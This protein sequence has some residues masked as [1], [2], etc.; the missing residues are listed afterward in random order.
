MAL[1]MALVSREFP[2]DHGGG[3]GSYAARIAR[4]LAGIGVRVHVITRHLT[5]TEREPDWP[6]G[7]TVHR[8]EMGDRSGPS[9]LRASMVVAAKILD[10]VRTHGLDAIEFAEYEAMGSAWLALRRLDA[11]ASQIPVA[12]HLHSPTELNA[13][14]NGYSAADLDP[15]LSELIE[16]ERR[17]IS[18]A[19]GVCAPGS[20]MADW[21]HHRYAL[22]VAPK[23]IPY[24][25][26]VSVTPR[27]EDDAKV[28]L[29]VGR[30]ERR[31]G[32]DTLIRAWNRVAAVRSGW[33]LHLVG[34]DTNTAPGGGS[35]RAW[36]EAMLEPSAQ[37]CT[38]FDAAMA[39]LQLRA[40]RATCS[41]AVIPSRWENF[42][43]TCIEAMADGLPV[44]ASDHGGMAEMLGLPAMS[45]VADGPCGSVFP[46]GDHDSLADSLQRWMSMQPTA[47]ISAGVAAQC[48]IRRICDPQAVARQ[49]IEWLVSLKANA[50]PAD[51]PL[52]RLL[53][54]GP[55]S[56]TRCMSSTLQLSIRHFDMATGA[57][58]RS[59][60]PSHWTEIMRSTLAGVAQRNGSPA[61]LYGAGHFTRSIGEALR[62]APAKIVCIIDDDPS[63]QG[64]S[65][66]G[67]PIVSQKEA[68]A[69]GVR[70]VVLSANQ[71][72]DKLWRAAQPMRDAGVEVVRLFSRHRPRVMIIESGEN[73]NHF[74]GVA[75]QLKARGIEVVGDTPH[76][77]Y[78][79]PDHELDLVCVADVLA[80]RNIAILRAARAKGIRTLLMMDGAVEYRNTFINPLAGP[81]FLRPAPIDMI[82]C[83]TTD[84]E[85]HL[86]ML[87]N[88]A[89]ATGLPRLDA[90][91]VVPHDPSGPVLISTANTPWFNEEERLRLHRV[92]SDMRTVTANRALQVRWRLTGGL[93]RALGIANH[94]GSLSDAMSGCRGVISTPST[95]LLEA[96]MAGLPIGVLDP[97]GQPVLDGMDGV[98][99]DARA[100][101]LID[102]IGNCSSWLEQSYPPWMSGKS[103]ASMVAEHIA[104]IVS[105]KGST[106]ASAP[107][108]ETVRLPDRLKRTG[109]PRAVSIIV[110][111]GSSTSGV[112]TF[113]LRMSEE[114]TAHTSGW[115]WHTLLVQTKPR[116]AADHG[117]RDLHPD[118]CAHVH[119]CVLD[120]TSDHHETLRA[121]REAVERLNP[122]VLVP[123]FSDMAW[124]V[125]AQ[126]R[127]RGVRVL[128]IMHSDDEA[129]RSTLRERP[130]WDAGVAVSA[131]CAAQMRRIASENFTCVPAVEQIT[132]GVPVEGAFPERHRS[133]PLRLLYIGRLVEHQK[134]VSRLVEVAVHLRELGCDYQLDVIGDG[135]CEKSL[136]HD[137]RQ[138]KL[139]DALRIRGGLNP[140]AV[141]RELEDADGLVLVSDFEGTSIAML[142]AMGKGVV[143]CVSRVRSGVDEWII[144]GVTG[145]TAEVGDTRSLAEKIA[146]RSSDRDSWRSMGQAAW[147][148]VHQQATVGRMYARYCSVLDAMSQQSVSPRPNTLGLHLTESGRWLKTWCDDEEAAI[149]FARNILMQSGYTKI[150]LN[151]P[152]PGCDA[153]LVN[154]D[155]ALESSSQINQWIRDGLGVAY[156]PL[157]A[158][159]GWIRLA[160]AIRQAMDRGARRI[161]LYGAGLHTQRAL[162]ML[163]PHNPI[164][165]VIDDH[166]G[167]IEICGLPIVRPNIANARLEPDAIVLSSDTVEDR[168]WES[169]SCFRETG[170][171]VYRVYGVSQAEYAGLGQTQDAMA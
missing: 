90:L 32:V 170:L 116:N 23:V 80:P 145:I 59:G 171:P 94:P 161:A 96:A 157:I 140:E 7:V 68:I 53:R 35:C 41:L 168:L 48:Q 56:E 6:T 34:A 51:E 60:N 155:V 4:A 37:A 70:T 159:P 91:A 17:C 47:R 55:T 29:Y 103:A 24:P 31:K 28:L 120:P 121:C 30:L 3:I 139:E 131:Q 83:A 18:L 150:A 89:C 1:R 61:A 65:M 19:D 71:W 107:L 26:E 27:R 126:I 67:L 108:L 109:R 100:D 11:D 169:C 98:P 76:A 142:E 9:C 117:L 97:F 86:Q 134:R 40:L 105:D 57:G 15:R 49:R 106:R 10:L 79:V 78:P 110:C 84:D 93:D 123:N 16:A 154:T 54:I 36:L 21:A 158:R 81:N 88:N 113:S 43:N 25:A 114:S 119:V 149:E 2:P 8:I 129:Y 132:Y 130:I 146:Q 73:T 165:G 77:V 162:P 111:D 138:L 92:M 44:V 87:G 112:T 58:S 163:L 52:S 14:L 164:V 166:S 74:A 75:D 42:P 39:P 5:E 118:T 143:P 46:A 99:R 160:S 50:S 128:G 115:E 69:R 95:V 66:H 136:K 104:T 156:V 20:F 153:V 45:G 144:D 33:M 12:I 64:G 137:A 122:D 38:R 151:E 127:Y 62:N 102:A 13:E 124:A 85:H 135:P 148:L 152:E 125:A 133:G 167:E 72:E 22:P 101:V 141:Q 147:R 82:C 63:S